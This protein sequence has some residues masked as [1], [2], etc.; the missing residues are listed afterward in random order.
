MRPRFASGDSRRQEDDV[1]AVDHHALD[2]D[3]PASSAPMTSWWRSAGR[4]PAARSVSS[5][6]W[7]EQRRKRRFGLDPDRDARGGDSDPA[8]LQVAL[9]IVG[10]GPAATEPRSVEL[11]FG[12]LADAGQRDLDGDEEPLRREEPDS[13][14]EPDR[15]RGGVIE[16]RRRSW[17]EGCDDSGGK[18]WTLSYGGASA[19]GT[20]THVLLAIDDDEDRARR[21]AQ[22]IVDLDLASVS[23][24]ILHVFT[25]NTEGASMGQFAPAR[26]ADELLSAAEI[27]TTL[28]ET[29]GEPGH[30]VLREADGL[31]VDLIAV[32]GRKRSPAGKAV[33][34]S[35]SQAVMLDAEVPVLYCPVET[36]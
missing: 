25:D 21:Q 18:G 1:I 20:M 15:P 26:R 5:N 9:E 28:V 4:P 31:D 10:H 27:E 11:A 6:D 14:D 30:E 16:G 24:T 12:I 23:V 22:E 19:D 17:V 2:R 8:A 35:V 7:L 29:S 34:G 3:R 32:A 33:F 13:G 36:E